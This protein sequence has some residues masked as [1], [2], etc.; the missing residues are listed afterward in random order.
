MSNTSQDAVTNDVDV[1]VVGSGM[2]GLSAALEAAENGADVLLVDAETTLGGASRLSTGIMMAAGTSLQKANGL[3]DDPDALFHDY[4]LANHWDVVPSVVRRLVD[5]LPETFE[6]IRGLGVTFQDQLIHAGEE[7]VPRGHAVPGQGQEIVD[8]LVRHV[9]RHPK[10]DIALDQRVDRLVVEDGVV[11]GIAAGDQVIRADAVVLATGGFA[12]NPAL[13]EKYLPLAHENDAYWYIG[14][15]FPDSGDVFG[16]VEPVGA[17]IEGKDR[18]AWVLIADFNRDP[19]AYL[20]GWLVIVNRDGRRFMDEMA[21]YSVA[22]PI[23]RA[24]GNRVFA[25]FDHAAKQAASPAA[26]MAATKVNLSGVPRPHFIEPVI[27]EAIEAGKVKTG[28]T[29][30]DLA[31]QLGIPPSNLAGTIER[32]NADAAHKHD[33]LFLKDGEQMRPVDQGPFYGCELRLS[34]TGLTACGPAVDSE[35]RVLR[36]DQRPVPGLFAAGECTGGVIGKVYIGSGNSIANCLAYGRVA[37]RNAAHLGDD[38]ARPA[39]PDAVPEASTAIG[40]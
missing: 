11:R 14:G 37:G 38:T 36:G 13:H 8:V 34:M 5:E 15:D 29:L 3:E 40:A 33:S 1:V 28:A 30:A 12:G 26:T 18:G 17:Y 27:D 25:I 22:D 9:R 4:M 6:W 32:Y 23:V 35:A 20:P 21:P 7:S 19:Q 24:Q 16:L 31:A 2:A 10:I 39:S